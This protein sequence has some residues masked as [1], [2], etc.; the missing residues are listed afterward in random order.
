MTYPVDERGNFVP[1][2]EPMPQAKNPLLPQLV[3]ACQRM[4]DWIERAKRI[5][6]DVILD[7]QPY[8]WGLRRAKALIA[9]ANNIKVL[10]PQVLIHIENGLIEGVYADMPIEIKVL[11]LD[12]QDIESDLLTDRDPDSTNP[13]DYGLMMQNARNYQETRENE[14]REWKS[15]EETNVIPDNDP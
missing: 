2:R 10:P 8:D 5:N 3:S 13:I 12:S 7:S 6:G 14:R 15:A 9:R 11:D 4:V 1:G